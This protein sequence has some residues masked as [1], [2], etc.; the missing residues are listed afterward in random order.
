MRQLGVDVGEAGMSE[1]A[2]HRLYVCIALQAPVQ[3]PDRSW[4][5]SVRWAMTTIATTGRS[6]R[7]ETGDRLAQAGSLHTHV[8]SAL[9]LRIV[10]IISKQRLRA[11][12]K[13]TY[14]VALE[15]ALPTAGRA[16]GRLQAGPATHNTVLACPC[17]D[18]CQA[19]SSRGAWRHRN[20]A[21][22]V[23]GQPGR[24]VSLCIDIFISDVNGICIPE[25]TFQV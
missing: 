1:L 22:F 4:A 3:R 12:V 2:G 17:P 8:G 24:S 21:R 25:W 18:T 20:A 19:R 10:T 16:T 14:P 13:N 9:Y 23:K 5:P 11:L 15:N 6:Q 7:P